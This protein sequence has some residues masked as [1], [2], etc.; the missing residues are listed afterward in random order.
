MRVLS[1]IGY[2][3]LMTEMIKEL[4]K[5]LNNDEI[6]LSKLY[7]FKNKSGSSPGIEFKKED[8]I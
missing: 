4:R 1:E 8:F 5:E 6:D 7:G 3:Q 2:S